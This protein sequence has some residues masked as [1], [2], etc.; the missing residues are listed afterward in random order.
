MTTATALDKTRGYTTSLSNRA[1]MA[2]EA[3]AASQLNTFLKYRFLKAPATIARQDAELRR[4]ADYVGTLVDDKKP[5][6][7]QGAELAL[8]KEQRG[9]EKTLGTHPPLWEGITFGQID[10][11]L[12]KLKMDGYAIGTV[13]LHLSTLKLYA[14][15]AKKAGVLTRAALDDITDLKGVTKRERKNANKHRTEMGIATRRP[16]AKKEHARILS[17]SELDALAALCDDSDQGRRDALVLMLLGGLGLR[18][19]E[20]VALRREHF[21]PE[22]RRLEVFRGKTDVTTS[23]RLSNGLLQ[24]MLGYFDAVDG[25]AGDQLLRGSTRWGRLSGGM[26]IRAVRLRIK[27]LGERIGVMDLAPHDFRHSL[28]TLKAPHMPLTALMTWF[29]WTSPVTAMTYVELTEVVDA[30]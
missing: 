22:T 11:F 19:S 15:M 8:F 27:T 26:S 25:E 1:A 13:N 14:K 12:T 7:D 28:A 10:S 9:G 3:D 16:G 23:F 24:A 17:Q 20:A 30:G 18:V 5:D 2:D 6:E 29:G 4:F 21:D